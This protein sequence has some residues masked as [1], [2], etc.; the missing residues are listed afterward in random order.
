MTIIA[1]K[2]SLARA[3]R[4]SDLRAYLRGKGWRV[5]PFPNPRVIYFEGPTDDQGRPI[6]QL[7]PASETLSDY[8]Y[9]IQELIAALSR[10]EDRDESEIV[11]DILTPTC[12]LLRVRL[13]S[14]ETRTGTLDFGF[15]GRFFASLKN[16]LIFAAC[17][18]FRPQPFYPRAL[19]QAV[20]FAE[21]CRLRPAPAGSFVVE[22]ESPI[23][24][25]VSQS[26]K[27][28]WAYPVE[29]LV[30]L[31]LMRSLGALETAIETGGEDRIFETSA[32]RVNANICEALLGMKPDAADAKLEASV[33][34]S[35]AWPVDPTGTPPRKVAFEGR[36]FE[37]IN[38]IGYSLRTGNAPQTREV[39]GR[40]VRLTSEDPVAGQPGT[41]HVT[42]RPSEKDAPA[43]VELVLNRDQYRLACDAHRDGKPLQVI[44]MLG[45]FDGRKWQL[46]DVS[47]FTV[48]EEH[49]R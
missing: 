49:A 44:G 24:P 14:D 33:S 48:R 29:R 46:Y 7:V 8:S 1:D 34:W 16:L 28:S 21:K 45:K 39:T 18:E 26:Q 9:R 30:L 35:P 12:D 15:V 27:D 25:S 17:S 20:A 38:A 2:G 41:F 23:L 47:S 11:R 31:T 10:L 3:V 4:V 32:Q 13:D 6:V 22:V 19:K 37:Q 42:I 43:Q 40:V 36:A 5:K